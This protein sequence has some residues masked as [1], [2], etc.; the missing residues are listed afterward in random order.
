MDCSLLCFSIFVQANLWANSE[1][2]TEFT[3]GGCKGKAAEMRMEKICYFLFFKFCFGDSN[4]L[5]NRVRTAGTADI[6]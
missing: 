5:K 1:L 6:C 2:W 3:E 4:G